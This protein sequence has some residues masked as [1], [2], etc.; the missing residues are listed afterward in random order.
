MTDLYSKKMKK[1][2]LMMTETIAVMNHLLETYGLLLSDADF[3][4]IRDGLHSLSELV[5][6]TGQERCHGEPTL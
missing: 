4:V 5:D 3:A 2:A 6:H 1:E